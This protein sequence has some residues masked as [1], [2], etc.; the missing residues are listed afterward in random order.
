M[1]NRAGQ[2]PSSSCV[3]KSLLHR[4]LRGTA[5]WQMLLSASAVYFQASEFVKK[6]GLAPAAPAKTLR[7]SMIGPCL[8]PFFH[9]LSALYRVI[10]KK[11]TIRVVHPNRFTFE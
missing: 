5:S 4:M 7:F 10:V 6:W 11:T 9:K 1:L 2:M 3:R 8:Y